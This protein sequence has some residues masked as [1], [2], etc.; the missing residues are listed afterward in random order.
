MGTP[1][2]ATQI[3]DTYSMMTSHAHMISSPPPLLYRLN[4]KNR[5][6]S[7]A[8]YCTYERFVTFE[9]NIPRDVIEWG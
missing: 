6:F 3:M 8:S 1:Y 9:K 7:E 2:R 5:C 4:D